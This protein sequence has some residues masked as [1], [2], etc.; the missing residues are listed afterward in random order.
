MSD[1]PIRIGHPDLDPAPDATCGCCEGTTLSTLQP[2]KNR[3]G[4]SAIDYRVGDHGRFKASMLARL[5]SSAYP[6]LRGLGTRD[7]DDFSIAL[8]DSWATVCDVLSFY[9]ERHANEAFIQTALEQLSITEIA[10]LIGYRLNPGSAAEADLVLLMEDPPGA[11]PDVASLTVP[12]GTRVQ[13]QPGP[14]EEPQTFETLEKLEAR[15]AWNKM[16]ARQDRRITLQ[17]GARGT[18]LKG[19]ASGLSPGDAVLVVHPQRGI[20]GTPGFSVDST[21]WD[22]LRLTKVE[23]DADLDRTWVEWEGNLGIV[24]PAGESDPV[25]RFYALRKQASLFGYNAPHPLVLTERTRDVFGYSGGTVPANSPSPISGTDAD[26]GDWDFAYA[27]TDGGTVTDADIPLDAVHKE[28]VKDSWAVLTQPDGTTELYKVTSAN[29][30]AAAR[31]AI[32]GRATSIAPD[33]SGWTSTFASNYRRVSVFGASEELELAETPQYLPI[34]G[35]EIELD[36]NVTGLEEDRL[37]YVTGRLAQVLVNVPVLNTLT[38]GWVPKQYSLG[39]RL[40]LVL[41]PVILPLFLFPG[42]PLLGIFVFVD[43]DG[44]FSATIAPL[45]WFRAVPASEDALNF[46]ERVELKEL[47]P[48]APPDNAKLVLKTALKAVYDRP[49]M[50]IHGNIARASHGETVS[51]ILG[52]GNPVQPFQKLTLKQNPVTHLVAATE[53]GVQST[54]TLRIDGVKWD[55]LPDLYQRGATA[56]VFTTSLSDTGETTVHFGDGISGARPSAGRDNI[57]A[58]YRQGLGAAGNVRAGQLSLPLDQP[59]GLKEVTNPLAATGGADAETSKAARRNAPIYTLT[60]G[61]VVSVTDYRDFALGYPGIAKADAR[62]IWQ[63]ETR[64]IVV[65]VAGDDGKAVAKGGTVHNALLDAYRKYGDPLVMFDLLSYQPRTFRIGIKVA[66]DSAYD[67][68]KV[69]KDVEAALREA[70]SFEHRDFAQPVALSDVAAK[71]HGVKGVVAVDI[72]RL[73]RDHEPQETVTDH[74]LLESQTGR[75]G[76]SGALLPAEILTLHSAPFD[77]LEVMS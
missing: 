61:R 33:R 37:L 20:P 47:K 39:T 57:Q 11:E 70:Y 1:R 42:L 51:D 64:R 46:T 40:T 52:G 73:Y 41:P 14:D 48:A 72:D 49:S 54:L 3:P 4:L 56:R 13:S 43:E 26:S 63:G 66:V 28:F 22:F 6:A 32:S 62:W 60:L 77:K 9:Q 69:L 5:A 25:H 44:I 23:P 15:V 38:I 24:S 34:F 31:F 36:K 71:A 35:T 45:L 53:N 68:E 7:D 10:R 50:V 16:T 12:V 2:V 27:V 18:W 21:L 67:D 55:E 59:L 19:Q 29:T 17:A 75:S 74:M 76:P 58:E 65:T 30:D 8:I